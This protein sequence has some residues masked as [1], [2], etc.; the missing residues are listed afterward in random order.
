VS[1]KG[2]G[3]RVTYNN[4][5]AKGR[6]GKGITY[7]KITDKNGPAVR[8]CSVLDEDDIVIIAESGMAIRL[9]ATDVSQI[10]RATVGVRIV[11]L[12]DSDTVRDVA[13][14]SDAAE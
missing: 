12:K 1:E 3:K 7:L 10:G 8:I 13:L 4:F 9:S 2:F 11:N 5:P 6:G 14:L